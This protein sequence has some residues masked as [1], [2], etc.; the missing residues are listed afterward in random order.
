MISIFS[1][2]LSTKPEAKDA[3]SKYLLQPLILFILFV[4]IPGLSAGQVAPSTEEIVKIENRG[5][6]I[7]DYERAAIKATDLLLASEP[8]KSKLGIYL[9]IN[10][11]GTWVVYFGKISDAGTEFVVARSYFC[12][13]GLFNEMKEVQD[14][15]TATKEILHLAK[16]VE[17]ALSSI[18]GKFQRYNSNVFREKNSSITVYLTPGNENPEI[19]L[20]GGDFKFS[21]S[22]DGSE[23]LNEALLHK[24]VLRMPLNIGGGKQP[25]SAFHTHVLD[26]LPTETDVALVL[27]NPQLAP[28]FVA[29]PR[30]M[31][32]VDATGKI[33]IL[34]RQKK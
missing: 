8:N 9:A 29:G 30:W 13:D 21:I 10:S 6:Q 26:D 20:L 12:P 1:P 2:K 32:R 28:H 17:L 34:E 4:H 22:Q 27:L 18:K 3:F 31:S 19:I 15:Q 11:G 23:I 33:T 14:F 25:A 5:R 24:S 7:A 16:A